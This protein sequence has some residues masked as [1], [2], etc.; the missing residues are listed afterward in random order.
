MEFNSS[1]FVTLR[2]GANSDIK[3]DYTYFTNAWIE[4]IEAL[5]SHKDLGVQMSD[6][7]GFEKHM[8]ITIK[9]A[10]R[11]IGWVCRTFISRAYILLRGFTL[12]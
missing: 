1:K 10:K 9:K 12:L 2:Y 6:N 11:H 7:G 5:E 3:T 8:D 4:P